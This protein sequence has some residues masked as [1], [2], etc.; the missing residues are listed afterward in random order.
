MGAVL[1]FLVGVLALGGYL[2]HNMSNYDASI[3][4]YSKERVQ[5]MLVDAKTTLPRRDGDGH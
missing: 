4:A 3:F 1:V 2:F 5:A